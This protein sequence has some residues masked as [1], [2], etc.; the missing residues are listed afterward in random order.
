MRLN[1]SMTK[2]T[3]N[4]IQKGEFSVIVGECTP[5][6]R[7]IIHNTVWSSSHP[8][9]YHKHTQLI[10]HTYFIEQANVFTCLEGKAP[11]IKALQALQALF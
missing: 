5:V 3:L 6:V 4:R 1:S 11:E 2:L 8:F 9:P 10:S 7:K